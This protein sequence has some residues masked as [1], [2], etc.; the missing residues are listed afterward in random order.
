MDL[1]YVSILSTF[2]LTLFFFVTKHYLPIKTRHGKWPP[3][4]PSRRIIGHLHLIKQPLHR[5]LQQLSSTYGSIYFL[6]LGFVPTVVISSPNLVEECFTRNDIILA[7]RPRRR[8]GKHLNYDWT[9]LGSVPYG[10]LWRDLRRLASLELFSTVRLN[11][12]SEIRAEEMRSL[13]KGLFVVGKEGCVKV[14]LRPRFSELTFNIIMRMV[15]GKRYFGGEVGVEES[16][17]FRDIVREVFE[18]SGASNPVDFFPLLK[19]VPFQKMEA[20]MLAVRKKMDAFLNG[21]IEECRRIRNDTS[22]DE[23]N[24]RKAMIYR[25][26]DLQESDP[27]NYSDQIIKGIIMIM[28]IAGTDTSAVTMEW[29]LS[30]LLN[31]P[32]VLQKARVEIDSIVNHE[33]LVDESD[34]SELPYIHNIVSETLRLFPAAPLLVPHEASEDCTIG[35]YNVNK[36]TMVLIN[37]WAIHRDSE[38]WDDP[39]RFKPERFEGSDSETFK[40]RWIPFGQGRRSCPGGNLANKVVA[41]NLASLI[42]CFDW[43]KIDGKNVDLDEGFGLTMPKVRPLEAICRPRKCMVNV[44][45]QI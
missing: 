22:A 42:Q 43:E 25:L 29:A 2:L 33:R 20:K 44:L 24:N 10:P 35:G 19:W 7:N 36:G 1:Y 37:A 26:L 39:L 23:G 4:P 21:L 31:N 8:T 3:A 11:M 18:L 40:S 27:S 34:L 28:V 12:L 9:T 41:L 6:K 17:V 13:V 32:D 15:T 5:S 14:E 16:K 30:L 38:F 45:S